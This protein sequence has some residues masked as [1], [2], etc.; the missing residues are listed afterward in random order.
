MTSNLRARADRVRAFPLKQ[1]LVASAARPDPHDPCKWHTARG[2]LSVRG[3]KFFNWHC[4]A[5]GG[6]AIDLVIHLHQLSFHDALVWLEQ[7]GALSAT[8]PPQS[9]PPSPLRLPV[10]AP[11]QFHAVRR[12]LVDQRALPPSLVDA[13]SASGDLY[14]DSRANAVF[15][16]RDAHG[17]PVGA[18]LRGT[19]LRQGFGGQAGP[20][21][22]RGMAPGSRKDLGFFSVPLTPGPNVILCESAID[23]LS[24]HV[25]HPDHRCL[26]TAGARPNPAWLPDLLHQGCHILCGF[27]RDAV[28]QS[29]AQALLSLHPSVHLLLPPLH[30]WNDSL[31]SSSS[32]A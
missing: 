27:D 9:G 6:G 31:R 10:P 7:H 13:H 18:E 14:A 5:G 25:L 20:V 4:G 17:Q 26:S 22:W 28:G 24:C 23:A 16:L 8:N 30:D 2:V 21:A 3:A 11:G 29:M 19:R 12:Y 15:L 1:I 32:P